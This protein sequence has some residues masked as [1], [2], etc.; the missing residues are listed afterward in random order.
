MDCVFCKIIKG[1]IPSKKVYED[2]K[3]IVFYDV[4]PAAP[5][6]LLA[7]PL[8][9]I[10]T[11]QD[12]SPEDGEIIGHLYSKIPILARELNFDNIGYRVVANCGKDAG[13]A[14][15]HIHFHILSGRKFSWP[16]G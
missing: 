3:I 5:I 10:E 1:E 15:F 7:V 11:I 6:H 9:H 14:V 4:S 12:I 13:Q 2:E 16:P 8:K